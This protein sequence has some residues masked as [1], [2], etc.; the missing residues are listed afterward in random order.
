MTIRSVYS[1]Q[2]MSLAPALPVNTI[3]VPDGSRIIVRDIDAVEISGTVD[4]LLVVLNAAGGYLWAANRFTEPS[5][6]NAQWRGRQV[7]NPGQSIV[8]QVV[9]G[10]W[11]IQMS[12]YQ[13]SLT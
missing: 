13:L 10:T 11:E 4:A 2:I 12:G 9:S 8:A 1:I 7:Y 6:Y 3:E 5:N